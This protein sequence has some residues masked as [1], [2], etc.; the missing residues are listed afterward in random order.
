[1]ILSGSS[2]PAPLALPRAQGAAYL[3]D[4]GE[5]AASEEEGPQLA[6]SEPE[7][8]PLVS[9]DEL[10]EPA[11]S[12]G[13]EAS[14]DEASGDEENGDEG[15]GEIT[16]PPYQGTGMLIAAGLL[17]GLAA[18]VM[19]ARVARIQ[20]SCTA[21]GLEGMSVTEENL[22]TFISSSAECFIAGRG[23]NAAL[24][25]FQAAP[26]AATYGLA[27][28]GA[29]RR[30]KYDAALSVKTG[31]VDRSPGAWIG[32]GAALLSVGAVGRVIVATVRIRGLNPLN[33]VAAG[34]VDGE[35][36]S[37][38]FFDCYADR[39]SLLYGMH[40]LTSSAIGAGAG[41]LTYGL[42]YKSERQTIQKVYGRE[43]TTAFEF[44]VQPQ[45]ALS[46]TGASAVLRF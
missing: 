39:N 37:G 17:G 10:A 45:L 32:A 38:D 44:S 24:W 15:P 34:C 35:V 30:A 11:A 25:V 36:A 27:P 2:V 13:D 3:V 33:G 19:G 16:I 21:E 40:Q 31:E 18:G 4:D 1:M 22:E 20:R 41:M 14:G 12:E 43:S 26:N 23:A 28:A 29:M 42:V 8:E 46:Y 9:E 6:E 5:G 7:D